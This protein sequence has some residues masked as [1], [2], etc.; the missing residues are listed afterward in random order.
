MGV[1]YSTTVGYGFVFSEDELPPALESLKD[2][3]YL[4][5]EHIIPWLEEHGLDRIEATTVGNFMCG[6]TFIFVYLKKTYLRF[7]IYDA[8]GVHKMGTPAITTAEQFQL[9]RLRVLFGTTDYPQWVVSF[10]VS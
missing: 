3:D 6:E 10:N 2:G 7:G 5:E 9:N 8:D 1:D 4:G